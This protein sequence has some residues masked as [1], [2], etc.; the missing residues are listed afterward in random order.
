MASVL[1]PFGI[2]ESVFTGVQKVDAELGR[3]FWWCFGTERELSEFPENGEVTGIYGRY[4]VS[5]EE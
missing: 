5:K 3:K 4:G 2:C 1:A